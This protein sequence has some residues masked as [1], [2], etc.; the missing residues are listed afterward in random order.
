MADSKDIQQEANQADDVTFSD[1][2]SEATAD[3]G[4]SVLPGEV[5]PNYPSASLAQQ[6]PVR[7]NRS[8]CAIHLDKMRANSKHLPEEARDVEEKIISRLTSKASSKDGRFHT[9]EVVEII[10]DELIEE[11]KRKK[12]EKTNKKQRRMIC[13]ISS[14][15]FVSLLSNF[16]LTIFAVYLLKDSNVKKSGLMVGKSDQP[17]LVGSSDTKMCGGGALCLRKQDEEPPSAEEAGL[18]KSSGERRMSDE[19]ADERPVRTGQVE[20]YGGLLDLPRFAT[21]TLSQVREIFVQLDTGEEQAHQ[22]FSVI[23][24]GKAVSIFWI[25]NGWIRIDALASQAIMNRGGQLFKFGRPRQQARSLKAAT[26]LAA[27]G[28]D[29]QARLYTEEEFFVTERGFLPKPGGGVSRRLASDAELRGWARFAI[30][31]AEAVAETLEDSANPP[32][33]HFWF[34]GTFYR[35]DVEDG[36]DETTAVQMWLAYNMTTESSMAIRLQADKVDTLID[37]VAQY[38]FDY[39]IEKRTLI[40]C[41]PF[42]LEGDD[43]ST[44]PQLPMQLTGDDANDVQMVLTGQSVYDNSDEDGVHLFV[45]EGELQ[46]DGKIPAALTPPTPEQCARAAGHRTPH[47]VLAASNSSTQEAA[48]V[49]DSVFYPPLPD[50]G[51][52]R[53]L[54]GSATA[55]TSNE[56]WYAAMGA[57]DGGT[58]GR[59][60]PWATCEKDNARAQ[61]FYKCDYRGCNMN[62]GFAGSQTT[63]DWMQNFQFWPGGPNGKYHSGF[64]DHQ[65]QVKDCVNK[66]RDMLR[67]WGIKIDYIVG[68]SLG[69]AAATVYAQEHGN[70]LKGVVTFGAPKSN[71]IWAS[72]AIKGWRFLH[73]D[74]PV[75]SSMC[76]VGC[77]L[78]SHQHVLSSAYQYYDKLECW[79][80]RVARR[81]Q[82]KRNQCSKSW[83]KF[84]CWFEWVWIT[85][86]TWVQECGWKK[87]REVV[88]RNFAHPYWSFVWGVYGAVTKHGAYG[89]YPSVT[90]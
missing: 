90:L 53:R 29:H 77:A 21:N 51:E 33:S 52:G 55:S 28:S 15:L 79:N 62:L 32:L 84:W 26:A 78:Q 12:L 41:H 16:L 75:P 17:V 4:L 63:K 64:Y 18:N 66:Y 40:R 39:D 44:A 50:Q 59:F 68:H 56:L 86:S 69:G 34:Q 23:K 6:V 58:E 22:V 71:N 74:D 89:D 60:T 87:K 7:N 13:G 80:E 57:Y 14:V 81:E 11:R 20:S 36:T 25:H 43:N 72:S 10:R 27:G 37:M 70:G 8:T 65:N 46:K 83:W 49:N 31:V 73:S 2:D 35:Q 30:M 54:W 67:G 19:P 24:E 88:G 1:V 82:Q 61:F 48:W 85:V 9:T 5:A 45:K 76:F 3:A 42:R 38:K 47:V